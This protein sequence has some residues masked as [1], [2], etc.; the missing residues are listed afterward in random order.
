[1][2]PAKL[3]MSP[4]DFS[5]P[6]GEALK[7][8]AE[9]ASCFRADVLLVHVVPAIPKLD[10]VSEFFHEREY[11]EKLH[12]GAEKRLAEKVEELAKQGVKASVALGTGN[13][14]SGELLRIAVHNDV[15]L[16]V[17]STHG[18]TGWR[19][20]AFGSVTEKVVR[21]AACPVL[22]LRAHAQSESGEKAKADSAAVRA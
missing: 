12:M 10:S 8:A 15:D 14:V 5:D 21:L 16:I 7:T 20:L 18:M 4:I 13:D 19:K 11:E 1:M 3:I 17:I 22:V 2:M 6:S 9:L